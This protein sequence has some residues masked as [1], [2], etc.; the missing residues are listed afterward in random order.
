MDVGYN[1]ILTRPLPIP[2][3]DRI[4]HC[5]HGTGERADCCA[6]PFLSSIGSSLPHAPKQ[7]H[8]S[9]TNVRKHMPSDHTNQN[10]S[11]RLR[12]RSAAHFSLTF[13][14]LRP[15]QT[16]QWPSPTPRHRRRRSTMSSSYRAAPV[17]APRTSRARETRRRR[18]QLWRRALRAAQRGGT[19]L[20]RLDLV[21]QVTADEATGE[22]RRVIYSPL[23]D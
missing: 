3:R 6:F 7:R 19:E 23:G 13:D 5:C 10:R 21:C 17:P 11:E 14:A 1:S 15:L 12:L 18:G 20:H 16:V 22:L 4:D 8:C 2:P 9:C